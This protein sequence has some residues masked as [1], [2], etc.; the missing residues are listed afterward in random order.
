M[1]RIKFEKYNIF[2]RSQPKLYKPKTIEIFGR[3]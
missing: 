1:S 2:N 3:G